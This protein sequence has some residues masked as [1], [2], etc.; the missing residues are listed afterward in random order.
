MRILDILFSV[1][2]LVF[3]L[4]ALPLIAL[5]IRLDSAGSIFFCQTR[6]GRNEVPF[7]CIKFRTMHLGTKNVGTHD[8][9]QASVTKAGRW[10]RKLKIDEL[11]QVWNLVKGDMSLIGPRPSLPSQTDVIEQ[12]RRFGVYDSLPG[13]SGL[14]QVHKVDM[15]EPIRLARYDALYMRRRN[16]CLDLSIVL[17]TLIGRGSGDRIQV[18]TA[19]KA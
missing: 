19:D 2:I 12:R 5:W 15:S 1:F 17:Q 10:L 3:L 11:P 6:V 9:A 7:T 8:V 13:I 16:A 14:A 18:R 4:W